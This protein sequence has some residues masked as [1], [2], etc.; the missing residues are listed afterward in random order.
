MAQGNLRMSVLATLLMFAGGVS[1]QAAD[2]V[3]TLRVENV[4]ASNLLKLSN[5]KTAS[6]TL[7]PVLYVIHT[8]H[9]PLFTSG[10]PDRG[11][12]LDGVFAQAGGYYNPATEILEA[13]P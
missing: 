8:K 2:E 10:E 9:G 11:K 4:S 1:A 12:G 6:V 3:F 5:G 13:R 7:G